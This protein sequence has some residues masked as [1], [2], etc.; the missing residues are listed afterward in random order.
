MRALVVVHDPGSTSGLV[1]DRLR[2][3]GID[4]VELLVTSSAEEP[5]SNIA[6]PDPTNFDLIVP[7][8]SVW[9]IPQIDEISSWIHREFALLRQADKAGIPILG[10]CFGGQALASALGGK[11][12]RS[13]SHQVGWVSIDSVVPNGISNGPWMEWHYDC[14]HPPPDAEILASDDTY[15]QAFQVRN[16]VGVQFHPEVDPAHFDM[17]LSLGGREELDS[18]GID[19][20]ELRHEAERQSRSSKQNTEQLVDWFL[21]DVAG[22]SEPPKGRGG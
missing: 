4:L 17:W 1:G 3:H 6:F 11:T 19:V 13:D 5:V 16:H 2:Q 18:I 14:I 10:V 8:G 22:I 21:S 9:S 7:M 20:E 15:V 12:V